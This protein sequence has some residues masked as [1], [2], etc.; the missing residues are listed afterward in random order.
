MTRGLT[1]WHHT[2]F[3]EAGKHLQSEGYLKAPWLLIRV[4][5]TQDIDPLLCESDR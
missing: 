1:R 2:G 3:E 5:E 4:L